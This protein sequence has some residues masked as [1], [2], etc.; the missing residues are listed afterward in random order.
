MTRAARGADRTI[1]LLLAVVLL[2]GGVVTL[3]WGLA[4]LP[5]D[6]V[7]VH[8][9]PLL[10]ATERA[11]WP[12]LLLALGVLFI[13]LALRWLLAH[14]PRAAVTDVRLPGSGNGGRFNVVLRPVLDAACESLRRDP[15]IA[16]ASSKVRDHAG[17][18]QVVLDVTM[19]PHADL[20]DVATL[21]DEHVA[22]VHRMVGRSDLEYLVV[23]D[24]AAP[25]APGGRVL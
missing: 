16:G 12:W 6:I 10:A 24:V 2:A 22:D 4:V 15:R 8:I 25:V 5:T 13:L 11:W 9:D 18:T 1:V 14:Q 17:S 23:L 21:A 19:H 3:L 7:G 20:A